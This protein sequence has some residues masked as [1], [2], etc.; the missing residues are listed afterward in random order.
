MVVAITTIMTFVAR[1]VC[2]SSRTGALQNVEV[3][4]LVTNERGEPL[5]NQ[6]AQSHGEVR[7]TQTLPESARSHYTC[8]RRTEELGTVT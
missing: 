5:A 8:F 4:F 2:D 7:L 3:V 1:M 6:V